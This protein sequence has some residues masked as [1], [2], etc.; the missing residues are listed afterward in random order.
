MCIRDGAEAQ[1]AADQQELVLRTVEAYTNV[2]RALDNLKSSQAEEAAF[3]RQL[4]QTQQRFEVGL[5]AITDV[6]EARA[7]YDLSL[8][9]ISEPTRPYLTSYAV[10]CLKKNITSTLRPN[11]TGIIASCS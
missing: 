1:F 7:A 4:E 3:Q 11:D 9:H 6:H 10:F 8:I 2:L 5:I